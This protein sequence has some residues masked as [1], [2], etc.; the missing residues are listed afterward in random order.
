MRYGTSFKNIGTIGIE[1]REILDQYENVSAHWFHEHGQC[2]ID[3]KLAG[4]HNMV[5][6]VVQYHAHTHQTQTIITKFL[7]GL[8]YAGCCRIGSIIGVAEKDIPTKFVGSPSP[9]KIGQ[10]L[11]PWSSSRANECKK[12][13]AVAQAYGRLVSLEKHGAIKLTTGAYS[14]GSH[15]SG[16]TWF[17][18][19]NMIDQRDGDKVIKRWCF[20]EAL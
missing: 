12:Q 6:E 18:Y 15:C 13:D 5:I 16:R 7:T 1:L 2:S 8:E 19:S 17:V 4:G 14:E 9:K 10:I 11:K 20:N 3:S